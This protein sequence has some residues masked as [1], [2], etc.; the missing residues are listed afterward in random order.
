MPEPVEPEEMIKRLAEELEAANENIE[1]VY[2]KVAALFYLL[3]RDC[4]PIG[5]VNTLLKDCVTGGEPVFSDRIL[6]VKA[7]SMASQLAE[8]EYRVREEDAILVDQEEY[9][10]EMSESFLKMIRDLKRWFNKH[11]NATPRGSNKGP[12]PALKTDAEP[13]VG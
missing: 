7:R 8:G 12:P 13:K 11:N 9:S 2:S 10:S 1:T 5:T 3:M 4:L 6:A